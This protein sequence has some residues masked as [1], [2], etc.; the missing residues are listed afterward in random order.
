MCFSLFSPSL[1]QIRLGRQGYLSFPVLTVLKHHHREEI[2]AIGSKW[3]SKHLQGVPGTPSGHT[4]NVTFEQ[5][6]QK[7]TVFPDGQNHS[8]RERSFSCF[9]F[10][11][12]TMKLFFPFSQNQVLMIKLALTGTEDKDRDFSYTPTHK[13]I[14]RSWQI[15]SDLEGLGI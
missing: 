5:L 12:K 15:K 4:W 11:S 7:P 9:S 6:L 13:T 14:F 3:I 2:P 8:L 1:S 10:A